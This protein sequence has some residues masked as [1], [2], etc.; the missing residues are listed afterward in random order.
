VRFWKVLAVVVI[1]FVIRWLRERRVAQN[2]AM[3][4]PVPKKAYDDI[5]VEFVNCS[6]TTE[7]VRKS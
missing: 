4:K 1:F 3:E 7:D 6:Q 2:S 5:E